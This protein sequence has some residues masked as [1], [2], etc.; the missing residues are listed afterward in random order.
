MYD[1][2]SLVKYNTKADLEGGAPGSRPPPKIFP[3]KIFHSNIV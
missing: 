3:N 2:L 1:I